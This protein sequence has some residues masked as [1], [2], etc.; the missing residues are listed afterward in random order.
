M[1]RAWVCLKHYI[2]EVLSSQKTLKLPKSIINF[3]VSKYSYALGGF[4]GALSLFIEERRRRGELAMYA[5]PKAMESAWLTARGKGWVFRTGSAGEALLTAVAMGMVM[6]IY[7][8]S[9]N[10]PTLPRP[11]AFFT[12]MIVHAPPPPSP[13]S[14]SNRTTHNISPVS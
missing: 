2:Y 14:H 6:S 7:Q 1:T 13:L 10:S 8:V 9:R 3:F 12:H 5:L 4:L 11:T